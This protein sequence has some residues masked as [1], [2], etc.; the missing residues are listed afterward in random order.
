MQKN[1]DSHVLG[2][3][4]KNRTTQIIITQKIYQAQDFNLKP[5]THQWHA[6]Y[7]ER[8]S[9]FSTLRYNVQF[10]GFEMP[11]TLNTHASVQHAKSSRIVTWVQRAPNGPGIEEG[12]E[13]FGGIK[14][15][16][17]SE[18]LV[19]KGIGYHVPH[20]TFLR[21]A[22]KSITLHSDQGMPRHSVDECLQFRS[23]AGQQSLRRW[24]WSKKRVTL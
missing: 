21:S 7:T 24:I 14:R 17:M 1:D 22:D 5:N 3:G 2:K 23:V 16:G 18:V 11:C 13:D 8:G 15:I 4:R 6:L 20:V 19:H 10:S 12:Y 9:C